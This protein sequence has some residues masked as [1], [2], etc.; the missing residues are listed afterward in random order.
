MGHEVRQAPSTVQRARAL[1]APKPVLR[2]PPFTSNRG[3]EFGVNRGQGRRCFQGQLSWPQELWSLQ[4]G[5]PTLAP[6]A[7]KAG[8]RLGSSRT[9][10]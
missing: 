6:W 1:L 9:L 7:K 10:A 8:Q 2:V 3:S 4:A 5:K